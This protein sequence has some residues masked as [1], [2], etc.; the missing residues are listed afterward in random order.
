[1]S[2]DTLNTLTNCF[3]NP[4]KTL[5]DVGAIERL[6]AYG[7]D[8]MEA[9]DCDKRKAFIGEQTIEHVIAVIKRDFQEPRE[10]H[11]QQMKDRSAWLSAWLKENAAATDEGGE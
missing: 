2:T 1:M 8:R 4:I 7:L 10:I 11:K 6:L 9:T 3:P 5:V